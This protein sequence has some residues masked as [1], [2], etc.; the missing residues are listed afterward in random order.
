MTGLYD[1]DLTSVRKAIG[2]NGDV[3]FREFTI[4]GRERGQSSFC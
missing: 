1:A 2:N 4:R 3:E